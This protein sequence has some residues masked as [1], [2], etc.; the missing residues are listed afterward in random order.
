MIIK[1]YTPVTLPFATSLH[2]I[3]GFGMMA[4]KGVASPAY[5]DIPIDAEYNTK[6]EKIKI[7]LMRHQLISIPLL[8]SIIVS[9]LFN[10]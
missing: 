9:I 1:N 5:F 10:G 6:T 4:E 2:D 8:L 3:L 7:L